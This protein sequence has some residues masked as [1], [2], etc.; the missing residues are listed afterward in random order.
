MHQQ[1]IEKLHTLHLDAMADACIL[2]RPTGGGL[3]FD[4]YEPSAAPFDRIVG[5]KCNRT[6]LGAEAA[7]SIERV[8]EFR[9]DRRFD[10]L[11]LEI[12]DHAE[13]QAV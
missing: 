8:F 10:G 1:T 11:R 4:T 2:P 6:D 13:V 7:Q 3:H 12:A 9:D 5:G